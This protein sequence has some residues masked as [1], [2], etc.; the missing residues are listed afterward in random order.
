MKKVSI[1]CALLLVIGLLSGTASAIEYSID[2][3][4]SGNPGGWSASLKTFEKE[5]IKSKSKEVDV[6]IW[7]HDVPKPLI[8]A[9]FW[10]TYDHLQVSIVSVKVYDDNDLPGPW[11]GTSTKK[12]K[13]VNIPGTYKVFCLNM[14]NVKPDKKGGIIIAKVRF[15]CKGKCNKPITI[16]T[17]SVPGFSTVVGGIDGHVY[18]SK[19]KPVSF[20]IN[21]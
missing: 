7:L 13:D 6:D 2:F 21:K 15:L 12:Q 18:D 14:G 1:L 20:T 19:I 8:S 3:L 11:D 16:I 17:D 5:G 9:G 4:E 10:I